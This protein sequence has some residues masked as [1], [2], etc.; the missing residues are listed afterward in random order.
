MILRIAL[1]IASKAGSPPARQPRVA[2]SA[3]F[4]DSYQIDPDLSIT[5]CGDRNPD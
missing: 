4:I 2:V 3:N 5:K 1:R